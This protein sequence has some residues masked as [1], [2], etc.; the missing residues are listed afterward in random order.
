M[1][2]FVKE[3]IYQN[4]NLD[5]HNC[6]YQN[7]HLHTRRGR[8]QR[9]TDGLWDEN[10]TGNYNAIQSFPWQEHIYLIIIIIIIIL[11][12]FYKLTDY[13]RAS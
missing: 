7:V 10:N 3:S 9:P 6:I 1:W 2:R 5:I 11:V 4:I 8:A 12:N 13:T